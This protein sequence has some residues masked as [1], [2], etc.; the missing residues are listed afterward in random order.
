VKGHP[1]T[2]DE[3]PAEIDVVIDVEAPVITIGET[4]AALAPVVVEDKVSGG[5]EPHVRYRLDDGAWSDWK[6]ASEIKSVNVGE[7]SEL[8]VEAKDDE[9]N[10]ATASQALIRGRA[11]ATGAG[12]G[13]TVV[14]EGASTN[15]S[16]W[17]LALGVVG[18]ALRMARRRSEK[19]AQ[20]FE[21]KSSNSKVRS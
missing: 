2:M 3:T 7:A 10:V 14:G 6:L 20:S 13:C 1:E 11:I 5:T 18:A 9:G 19:L 16:P 12:C 4:E 15:N 17:F 21:G 8:T